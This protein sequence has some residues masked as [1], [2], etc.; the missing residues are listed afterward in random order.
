MDE[1]TFV[2][3]A[4]TELARI[5]AAL[6]NCGLDLDLERKSGSVLELGFAD[7][8]KIIINRHLGAR[9][10]W[11]AARSGGFHFRPE[12]GRWIAGRDGLELYST[13]SRVVGEQAGRA[14]NLAA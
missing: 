1:V 8:G 3:L 10:I 12:A 4:E 9:E 2:N 6:E 5:E 7:G 14:V 13:L 11:V